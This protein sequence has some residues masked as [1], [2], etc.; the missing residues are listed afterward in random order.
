MKTIFNFFL[1]IVLLSISTNSVIAQEKNNVTF[2]IKEAPSSVDIT[3]YVTAMEK[4][5]FS[6]FRFLN[7]ERVITFD[8]GVK[9]SLMSAMQVKL[10]S[11]KLTTN[12]Y[13]KEEDIT[14]ANDPTFQLGPN[15]YIL[16]VAK[17]KPN[18]TKE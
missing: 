11:V 9:I 18:K 15:G 12:C 6:C 14:P 10:S 7:N 16:M 13:A 4:A 1:G 8:T 17:A 2:S 3:T 5:D